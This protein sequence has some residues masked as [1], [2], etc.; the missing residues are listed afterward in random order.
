[1]KLSWAELLRHVTFEKIFDKRLD[2]LFGPIV[3]AEQL[4]SNRNVEDEYLKI[5]WR[6]KLENREEAE[7]ESRQVTEFL[8]FN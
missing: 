1:M 6:Q 2:K 5:F 4:C 8:S 3:H 7:K